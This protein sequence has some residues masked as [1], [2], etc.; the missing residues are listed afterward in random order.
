VDIHQLYID[1]KQAYGSINRDQLI[2]I[3]KEFGIPSK[4]VRLV[5]MTLE[6]TNNK[7]EIQGKMSPSFETVVGLMQGD[8]L[9]T[10]L[11][12]L[13]TERVIRNVKPNPG[14]TI[15]NRTRQ[16]VLYAADVVVFGC[17]VTHTAE[18]LEDMTTAASQMGLTTNV[19]KTK[20]M[21]NRKK[22][23]NE[24]EGTEI[25]EQKYE[26]A[27]MF[28][29][30]GSLI[31]NTNEVEAVIKARIIAGNKCYHTLGHLLKK[32]YIK[33]ALS[34]GL[35]KTITDRLCPMVLNHRP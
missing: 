3:I 30:L 27:E 33:Q 22:K 20:H 23:G 32:S 11:F 8:A 24:S 17:A 34:V 6:K 2:E 10:I 13:H 26:N 15:F 35:Y 14:G 9:C 18:T 21:I 31:T 25:N 4:I 29:Y 19:S 5:K 16:C 12:N 7:V 1:Y 28:K